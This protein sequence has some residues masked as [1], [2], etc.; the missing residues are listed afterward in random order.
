[1]KSRYSRSLQG[2]ALS[3]AMFAGTQTAI[4]QESIEDCGSIGNDAERLA[5]YD[6]VHS[7]P[8]P[9]PAPVPVPVPESEP[10]PVAPVEAAAE[11]VHEVDAPGSVQEPQP[12]V[13][14]LDD[15]VGSE[16]LDRKGDE[17][18]DE[19]LIRGHVRS[20]KANKNSRFFFFFDNGQVWKQKDNTRIP[21][22][23]CD[24]DVTIEK[25]FFGYKMTPDGERR[26]VRIERVE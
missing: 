13:V 12:K 17:R 14:A 9:A 1:M 15:E 8:S 20:C 25:D 6:R 4:A 16:T 10:A 18:D 5:C 3:L 24:F 23:D 11:P 26:R 2:F 21:W 19:P 22:R 7:Q